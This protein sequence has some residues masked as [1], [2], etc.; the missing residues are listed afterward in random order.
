MARFERFI[1]HTFDDRYTVVSIIGE[2]ESAIVFGA[3]D[4]QTG[5]T[6]ALKMLRP[7]CDKHSEAAERFESEVRL[8]SLFDHPN[9]VK[10]LDT[11]K[12]GEYRYFVMEYIEGITL[13]KHI[14]S[15]GALGTEEI[16]FLSRQILSALNHVHQRG[17]IHSDIKPQNIVIVGSGN[18]KLMDFGIA[19]TLSEQTNEISEVAVGTVQYV[20]PEQAEGKPLDHLSDLYSFGVMLYEMATGILPFIDENANKIAAMH[21]N[22]TPIPPTVINEEIPSGLDAI[23]LRAME[24]SPAD[25]F[26]SAKVLLRSMEHMNEG[27]VKEIRFSDAPPPSASFFHKRN[28]PSLFAGIIS[29]LLISIAMGLCVLATLFAVQNKNTPY[30]KIPSL[31]GESFVSVEAL[32]LDPDFYDVEIRFVSRPAKAGKILSQSP[33]GGRLVKQK[34]EEKC[35][36]VL[37]VAKL[38]LPDTLPNLCSLT[39]SEALTF[40]GIYDCDVKIIPLPHALLPKNEVIELVK[41]DKKTLVLY[42]SEGYRENTVTV[43]NLVGMDRDAAKALA[44]ENGLSCILF[45]GTG[46]KVVSQSLSAGSAV[47]GASQTLILITER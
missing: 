18:I 4:V 20:S 33:S 35:H 46:D 6:V 14:I 26:P 30:G 10:L 17:V 11:S 31:E 9:I 16:L 13:K 39:K 22:D 47:D 41:A 36:L 43:P 5:E 42:V 38:A 44:L 15:R 40:L 8:L 25:R 32:G 24:K 45:S 2:G 34:G 21:V 7:E 3:F 12:G 29:A 23:I 27:E 28:L 19:K 1:G 37:K